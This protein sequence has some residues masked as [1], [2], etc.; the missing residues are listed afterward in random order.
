MQYCLQIYNRRLR[1]ASQGSARISTRY[2]EGLLKAAKTHNVVDEIESNIDELLSILETT[3]KLSW[4]LENPTIVRQNKKDLVSSVLGPGLEL[5]Q[6]TIN[7]LFLLIDRN[8]IGYFSAI[9]EKYLKLVQKLK[10]IEIV[11]VCTYVPLTYKEEAEVCRKLAES[12]G[13][14]EIKLVRTADLTLLGGF[15][16]E[17]DSRRIDMS[18]KGAIRR[19]SN[20]FG[21][22]FVIS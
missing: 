16:L 10:G 17:V 8:R 9:G 21:I 4:F 6:Y 7:L 3:P 14:K 5:N 18:I 13:S 11:T 12:T 2:A 20:Y 22:P 15:I 1:V 19:L